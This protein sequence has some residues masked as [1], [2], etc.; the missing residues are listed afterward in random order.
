MAY[1]KLKYWFDKDLAVILSEKIRAHYE[2]LFVQKSVA[3]NLNDILK[4][5]YEIGMKTIRKWSKGATQN[6]QWIIKH[7]VRNQIKKGNAEAKR[8]IEE[9]N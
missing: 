9:L 6:R 4:D 2:S 5:N 3:N 8:I 7:A 1:K